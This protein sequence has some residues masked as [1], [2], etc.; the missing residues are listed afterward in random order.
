MSD[1]HARTC[2]RAHTHKL[3]RRPTLMEQDPEALDTGDLEAKCAQVSVFRDLQVW[4]A[5]QE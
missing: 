2:A 5:A 1:T 4:S 3:L